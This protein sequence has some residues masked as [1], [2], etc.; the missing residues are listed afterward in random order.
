VRVLFDTNVVLDVLQQ[1]EPFFGPARVLFEAVEQHAITGLLCANTLTTV[2]YFARK[3]LGNAQALAQ[4]KALLQL[5][6]IA[7]VNHA[8]LLQAASL[9]FT[10]FEDAVQHAS[11][12][13]AGAQ[14]IVSRDLKDFATSELT[15]YL[16]DELARLLLA[17]PVN[18]PF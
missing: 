9:D 3:Q 4:I 15:L 18:N 1:R 6:E 13:L 16:P 11:A 12:K 17:K 7:P 10:D 8:V 2:F 5:F 14:A